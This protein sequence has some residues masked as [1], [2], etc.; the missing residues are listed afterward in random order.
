MRNLSGV[1]GVH[2]LFFNPFDGGF[3]RFDLA[4]LLRLPLLNSLFAPGCVHVVPS[5]VHAWVRLFSAS[6][7]E[8]QLG[9][10]TNGFG[11]KGMW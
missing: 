4:A 1:I 2:R 9:T 11:G 5:V 7:R 6:L 10:L 3:G 8:R